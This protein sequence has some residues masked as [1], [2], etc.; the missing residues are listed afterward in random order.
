LFEDAA[1]LVQGW[2]EGVN[3][4]NEG[5][6][7]FEGARDRNSFDSDRKNWFGLIEGDLHFP[8]NVLGGGG[9][10][11]DQYNQHGCCRDRFDDLLGP[12]ARAADV[13]WSHPNP[14]AVFS[15][16]VSQL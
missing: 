4:L 10:R 7:I 2:W 1:M 13:L 8:P 16:H 15:E 6:E 5:E 14:V 9:L 3:P 12:R 11:G